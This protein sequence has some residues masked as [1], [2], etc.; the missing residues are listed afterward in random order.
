MEEVLERH[1]LSRP[2][3]QTLDERREFIRQMKEDFQIGSGRGRNLFITVTIPAFI[4]ANS[5][6][7]KFCY[8]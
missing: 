2:R 5:F 8:M 7:V 3:S 1:G 6:R 4:G